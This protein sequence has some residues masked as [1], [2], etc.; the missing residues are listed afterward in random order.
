MYITNSY[1]ALVTFRSHHAPCVSIVAQYLERPLHACAVVDI[2]WR[3][4]VL[5]H[6]KHM[7]S[8]SLCTF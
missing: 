7:L 6:F 5:S 4:L 8:A 3:Q 2:G 1:C